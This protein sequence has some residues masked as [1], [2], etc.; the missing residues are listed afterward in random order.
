[1]KKILLILFLVIGFNAEAQDINKTSRAEKKDNAKKSK[2]EEKR[3]RAKVDSVNHIMARGLL[4]SSNWAFETRDMRDNEGARIIHSFR[5]NLAAFNGVDFFAEVIYKIRGENME[6]SYEQRIFDSRGKLLSQKRTKRGNIIFEYITYAPTASNPTI[7]LDA[8]SNFATLSIGG[9]FYFGE[10][11]PLS[12]SRY[13]MMY[14]STP[15]SG[16]KNK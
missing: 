12:E 7:E 5:P 8:H 2:L 14:E 6:D 1:M 3:I 13:I 10:I 11:I 9:A 16:K 4:E 15:H